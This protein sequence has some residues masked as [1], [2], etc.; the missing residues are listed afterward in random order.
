MSLVVRREKKG[1]NTY[2]HFGTGN[3]H[4]TAKVYTDLSLFTCNKEVAEDAQHFLIW[5]RVCFSFK[6]NI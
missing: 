5:L 4:N 3:Y 1:L 2:V 6:W